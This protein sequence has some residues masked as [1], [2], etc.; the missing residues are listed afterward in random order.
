MKVF[1]N[2]FVTALLM[3]LELFCGNAG[4]APGL[5]L[6]GATYFFV[7]FSPVH[8]VL[9]AGISALLLDAMYMRNCFTWPVFAILA[10]F[11]AG[12]FARHLQ[13]RMP[14]APLGSGSLC[15]LLVFVYNMLNTFFTGEPLPGPDFFSLL[16]FQ[17]AGG[18]L[19]MLFMVWLFDAINYR[20]NLPKFCTIEKKS[21]FSGGRL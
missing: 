18:G 10:V 9:C 2:I 17:F 5:P 3:N 6:L 13:R 14:L 7:T 11:A 21:N 12:N 16:V 19:L 15:A 20:C 4:L 8:G 1:L